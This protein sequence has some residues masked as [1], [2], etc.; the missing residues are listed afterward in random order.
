ME[1]E[2]QMIKI[3]ELKFNQKIE[4]LEKEINIFLEKKILISMSTQDYEYMGQ[5]HLYVVVAYSCK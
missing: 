2:K 5:K 3:F 1:K 4:E